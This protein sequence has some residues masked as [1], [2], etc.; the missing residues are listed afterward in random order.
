MMMQAA[1]LRRWYLIHRWTSL[2][3]TLFLLVACLTGLPLVFEDELSDLFAPHVHPASSGAGAPSA[4]LDAMVLQSQ[5]IYPQ[6]HPYAIG[7]DDDEPR[8]FINMTATENPKTIAEF[9]QVIFDRYSGAKL[10][11]PKSGSNLMNAV[12]ELHRS[13]FLGLPGELIMAIVA[14]CFVASLVSGTVLYAPFMR[15]LQF[16]TYRTTG[17]P[18]LRWFDLHNVVGIVT[19]MWMLVVGTTG[20]MNALATPLFGLWRM[21]TMPELLKPYHGKTKPVHLI[22]VD[23]AVRTAEGR[24]PSMEVAS[25]LFPNGAVGSPLHYVVWMKGETAVTARLMTPALID[26]NTGA[27]TAARRLPWYLRALEVSRPLHFGDYGG[28]PLKILWGSFDLAAI[29][30]LVSGVILWAKKQNPFRAALIE[31]TTDRTALEAGA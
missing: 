29:L 14:M 28:M 23:E 12:L 30:V 7:F 16:G 21:Q 3:C 9:H 1:T 2:V 31:G 5:Q 19:L 15:H 13:L 25:V 22:R 27:L 10:E 4:S 24:L 6:L 20:L 17:R 11:Q 8:V 18:Q 26:V